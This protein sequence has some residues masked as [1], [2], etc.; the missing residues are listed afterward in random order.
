MTS[1]TFFIILIFTG[2]I[3]LSVFMVMIPQMVFGE[4]V[5]HS[6]NHTEEPYVPSGGEYRD[7]VRHPDVSPFLQT[8]KHIIMVWIEIDEPEEKYKHYHIY[9]LYL[10]SEMPDKCGGTGCVLDKGIFI[11]NGKQNA[12]PSFGGCSVLWHEILHIKLNMRD[13]TKEHMWMAENLP[14]SRCSSPQ[15]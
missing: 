14:N 4:Y 10:V 1:S 8:E 13:E 5:A 3:T 2:L 11:L 6:P 15:T 12:Q 9:P 7:W